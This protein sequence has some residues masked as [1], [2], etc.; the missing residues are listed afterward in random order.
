MSELY[1]PY[2]RD[3]WNTMLSLKADLRF[4]KDSKDSKHSIPM[5]FTKKTLKKYILKAA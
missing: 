2:D 1:G 4:M 3:E 5:D